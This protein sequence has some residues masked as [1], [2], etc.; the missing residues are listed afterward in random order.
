MAHLQGV[1]GI[2]IPV[3]VSQVAHDR[4]VEVRGLPP[5]HY[6]VDIQTYQE[7]S[8]T[9][10]SSRELDVSGEPQE[11]DESEQP[12]HSV[13]VSGKVLLDAGV[14]AP[15]AAMVMLQNSRT[16]EGHNAQLNAQGEFAFEEP[17]EPGTYQVFVANIRG[18]QLRSIKATGAHTTGR[19]VTIPQ[20]SQGA[21]LTI[22]ASRA[23]GTVNGTALNADTPV[24]GAMIVLVPQDPVAQS[25][26][27]RR[28]QS[29]SDGTFTLAQVVP[30][31]YTVIALRNGWEMEW[32]SPE[33]IRGYLARGTSVVVDATSKLEVRVEVQ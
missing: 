13:V 3:N 19:E 1:G 21:Q 33:A 18:A 16:R 24:P 11:L 25:Y 2:D 28:D 29:D 17:V 7:T 26:L 27:I 32:N 22:I 30:G 23:L 10:K 6:K 5:G 4:V 9:T 15:P 31:R 14:P 8:G 20:Q 12:S